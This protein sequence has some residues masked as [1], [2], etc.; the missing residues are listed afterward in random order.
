[1]LAAEFAPLCVE[2]PP[3]I[4][5]AVL[6]NNNHHVDRSF[7]AAQCESDIVVFARARRQ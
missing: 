2:C 6:T 5:Q 4:S 3:D 1:M 7:A